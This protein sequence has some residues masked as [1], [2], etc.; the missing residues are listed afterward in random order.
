V[1]LLLLQGGMGGI[2]TSWKHV[3][4]KLL[5][6]K[7]NKTTLNDNCRFSVNLWY[8]MMGVWDGLL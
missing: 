3:L 5:R 7:I 2:I 8:G 6:I 4:G 1:A